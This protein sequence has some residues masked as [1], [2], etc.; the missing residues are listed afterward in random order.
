M[1][2]HELEQTKKDRIDEILAVKKAIR[3]ELAPLLNT[4][5]SQFIKF[6]TRAVE[7]RSYYMGRCAEDVAYTEGYRSFAREL[8]T[9]LNVRE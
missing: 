6:L 1:G 7:S 8:L 5:N 9:T 2:W 3:S 4:P